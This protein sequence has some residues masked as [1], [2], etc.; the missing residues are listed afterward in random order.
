MMME[1]ILTVRLKELR[2]AKGVEQ[3]EVGHGAGMSII[4]ISTMKLESA[5]RI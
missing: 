1:D 4:F 2:E 5:N 3:L